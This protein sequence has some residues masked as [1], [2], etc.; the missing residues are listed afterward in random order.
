MACISQGPEDGWSTTIIGFA[1][2]RRARS[3]HYAREILKS[4]L[5]A[6]KGG[7]AEVCI[8]TTTYKHAQHA[9]VRTDATEIGGQVFFIGQK[10]GK[11]RG[12]QAPCAINFGQVNEGK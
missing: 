1:A 4:E 9:M 11:F 3:D 7:H 5:Q 6:P 10:G 12:I 8:L 2:R